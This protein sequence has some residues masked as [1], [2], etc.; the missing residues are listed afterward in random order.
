MR[1]NCEG[2]QCSSQLQYGSIFFRFLFLFLPR[3]SNRPDCLYPKKSLA[4]KNATQISQQTYFCLLSS[5]HICQDQLLILGRRKSGYKLKV[6]SY[7][8]KDYKGIQV[9]IIMS[10]ND[11]SNLRLYEAFYI[12]KCKPTLN[13]REESSE[14][15]DLLCQYFTDHS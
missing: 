4:K 6:Y 5:L 11:P 9:K 10:E 14:F 8:N 3:Q 13:S 7:Q 1:E 15:A 2:D 12:R